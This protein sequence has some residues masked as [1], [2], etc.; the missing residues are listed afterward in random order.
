MAVKYII[1]VFSYIASLIYKP[2]VKQND[3][4]LLFGA[5]GGQA[6]E[7]NSKYLFLYANR[8]SNYDCYWVSQN[9]EVI[10]EIK[11]KYGYKAVHC[12]SH[13][14]LVLSLR[15]KAI[16]ITHSLSDILLSCYNKNTIIVNLY[17]GIPIKNIEFLDR[18]IGLLGKIMN[19]IKARKTSIFMSNSEKY[20][21]IYGECFKLPSQKIK[22]LGNP[23]IEYLL[24]PQKFGLAMQ[25]PFD[26]EKVYLYVPTFRDYE[27]D[28]V[29][30]QNLLMEIEKLMKE[31]N[32]GFYIKL[33]PFDRRKLDI[34]KYSHIKL[35]QSNL[36]PQQLLYYTDIL[37]TDYSSIVFDYIATG[38]PFI[39]YCADLEKYME[40]RGFIV[41]F[42]KMFTSFIV[43][44]NKQLLQRLNQQYCFPAKE[45]IQIKRRIFGCDVSESCNNILN[46][47]RKR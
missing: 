16:F 19:T 30:N 34:K 21:S 15:A 31:Q 5:R 38:K 14:A 33:H 2:F 6:F 20:N 7:G 23:K 11:E 3:K 45:L 29:L 18:N 27:S 39:L 46:E 44:S 36:D 22:V 24:S 47:I 10:T 26:F 1:Y 4:I 41:D 9:T 25:N 8:Y 28:E 37:I 40:T 35:I 42:K 13:K 17:H 32:S 43:I 12:F